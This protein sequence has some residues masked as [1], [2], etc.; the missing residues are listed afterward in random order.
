MPTKKPPAAGAS[1]SPLAR[2]LGSL[3]CPQG[4]LAVRAGDATDVVAATAMWVSYDPVIVAVYLKPGSTA[5]RLVSEAR[6]FTF[7]VADEAQN[8]AALKA[9]SI[10]GADAKKLARLGL[11][12]EAGSVPSPRVAGAAASYDCRVLV[13]AACGA[14][15][16]FLGLVRDSSVRD[17][18]RPVVRFGGTSRGVGAALP[19]PAVSYPH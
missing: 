16:L 4:L 11:A 18:A 10:G 7:N 3:P 12:L 1:P 13:V 5:H 14:H 6:H 2:L 19:G 15:D 9:G 17:G 8:A